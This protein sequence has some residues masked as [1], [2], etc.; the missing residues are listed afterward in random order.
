MFFVRHLAKVPESTFAAY[1][2]CIVIAAG[3]LKPVDVD[4]SLVSF[5]DVFRYGAN[6]LVLDLDAVSLRFE[7][8]TASNKSPRKPNKAML[9][10][11]KAL[12]TCWCGFLKLVQQEVPELL[13]QTI[14]IR[15]TTPFYAMLFGRPAVRYVRGVQRDSYARIDFR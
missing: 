8:R 11:M 9:A 14:G 15:R 3:G 12:A 10:K 6:G 4:A 7:E 5:D 1:P 2:G 13:E